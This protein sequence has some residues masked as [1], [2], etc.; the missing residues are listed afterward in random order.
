L[1]W[2]DIELKELREIGDPVEA[3]WF[4]KDILKIVK[5][6]QN[7]FFKILIELWNKW[8]YQLMPGISPLTLVV[9][10][11]K[12]PMIELKEWISKLKENQIYKWEDWKNKIKNIIQLNNVLSDTKIKLNGKVNIAKERIEEIYRV[13]TELEDHAKVLKLIWES[14]LGEI[15]DNDWKNIWNRR[16]YK[17]MCEKDVGT[18][19]H[20]WWD[21]DR[22]QKYGIWC[23]GEI[24][25]LLNVNL[26][27]SLRIALLLLVE[28]QDINETK[29]EL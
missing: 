3:Y 27:M 8:R 6:I 21:C 10:I 4:K 7:P 1:I 16:V 23:L 12:F 13:L 28:K 29:K 2:R 24:R 9:E 11:E 15:N 20:I 17:N 14:D 25:A 5:R 26:D 19:K 22:T 18:Y